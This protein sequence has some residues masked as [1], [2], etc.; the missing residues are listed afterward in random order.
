MDKKYFVIWVPV[1]LLCLLLG[2][3]VTAF[4]IANSETPEAAMLRELS[5]IQAEHKN[6]EVDDRSYVKKAME[7]T[8]KIIRLNPD[9]KTAEGKLVKEIQSEVVVFADEKLGEFEIQL[10]L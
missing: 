2:W 7:L 9:A 5:E 8:I 3:G 10:D 4:I 1:W 6:G